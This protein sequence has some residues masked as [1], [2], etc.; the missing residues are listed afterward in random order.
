MLIDF[1]TTILVLITAIYAYLTH[2]I[3]K[4]S[5]RNTE[6][7][8]R[9]M[10]ASS[11][12]KVY[13]ILDDEAVVAARGVVKELREMPYVDWKTIDQWG[14]KEGHVKTLLRAYNIAGIFVKHGFLLEKHIVPDWEP[15]IRATWHTLA[16][17]VREQRVLNESE[18]HWQNYEWLAKK[19]A[20]YAGDDAQHRVPG[21]A[22]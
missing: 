18:N 6:A 11:F 13:D 2:K 9:S 7:L 22:L 14:E 15:N 16:P 20:K 1:L 5:E 12:A 10:Y 8:V 17:Y 4:A 19:A 21:D 3:A